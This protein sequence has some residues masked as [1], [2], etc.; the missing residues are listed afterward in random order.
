MPRKAADFWS[1]VDKSG[2]CWLWVGS[3]DEKGY[4]TVRYR[5][6]T[7]KAHRVSWEIANAAPAGAMFVCHK[8]DNPSCVRPDHLFLGTNHDNALDRHMKG[9]S[10]ALFVCGHEINRGSSHPRTNLTEAI[11]IDIRN[12]HAAGVSQRDLAKEHGIHS[13]QISRIV[14]R[15]N[16]SHV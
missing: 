9:R 16:W 8:C 1:R 2:D 15:R 7:E 3:K 11:V 4:G 10:K 13:S 12:Q 6:K 14:N 5:G